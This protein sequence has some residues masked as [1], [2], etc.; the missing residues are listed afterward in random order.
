MHIITFGEEV[1]ERSWSYKLELL[2]LMK[3]TD[4]A[5]LAINSLMVL[6][7]NQPTLATPNR[8]NFLTC[9]IF[10]DALSIG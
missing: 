5:I 2:L 3:I 7:G 1:F 4:G 6:L 9:L 8:D 10:F